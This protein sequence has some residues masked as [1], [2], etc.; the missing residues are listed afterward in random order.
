MPNASLAAETAATIEFTLPVDAIS[1][2][3]TLLAK[4]E[5][6]LVALRCKSYGISAGSLTSV[7]MRFAD[8]GDLAGAATSNVSGR[9]AEIEPTYED[10]DGPL[11]A[12]PTAAPSV[13]V[14]LKAMIYA[15]SAITMKNKRAFMFAILLPLVLI[16]LSS[17]VGKPGKMLLP[18]D[19]SLTFLPDALRG[20]IKDT[21]PIALSQTAQDEFA[22]VQKWLEESTGLQVVCYDGS[23]T[24]SRATGQQI[25]TSYLNSDRQRQNWGA[26]VLFEHTDVHH[27]KTESTWQYTIMP[28]LLEVH[29]LPT[30]TN[31]INSAILKSDANTQSLDLKATSRSYASKPSDQLPFS[32]GNIFFAIALAAPATTFVAF[33]VRDKELRTRHQLSVM[34]LPSSVYWLGVFVHDSC[35]Y[36]VTALGSIVIMVLMG[37]EPMG[38]QALGP[39]TVLICLFVPTMVLFSYMLSYL[40]KTHLLVYQTVP[41]FLQLTT[42]GALVASSVLLALPSTHDTAV[43]LNRI[44]MF[45]L[46][47]YTVVGASTFMQQQYLEDKQLGRESSYWENDQVQQALAA[48]AIMIPVFFASLVALDRRKSCS[49]QSVDIT[50]SSADTASEVDADVQAEEARANDPSTSYA[51]RARNLHK[52]YEVADKDKSKGK[53]RLMAV[54]NLSLTVSEGECLGCESTTVTVQSCHYNRGVSCKN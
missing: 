33:I 26:V 37:T 43:T 29:V 5:S 53:R 41:L 27:V 11:S 49:R 19:Q 18:Q 25:A 8:G 31:L 52:S 45:L 23:A 28:N 7:F 1:K 22:H 44:C 39:Y 46:P 47:H 16:F 50:N 6:E 21:L 34:G 3:A 30:I 12:Q 51:I 48:Y 9:P 2:F 54:N 15:K 14:Q 40:F 35:L 20:S 38:G 32:S 4:L 36:S 17:R 10:I 24:C 42:I 13:L